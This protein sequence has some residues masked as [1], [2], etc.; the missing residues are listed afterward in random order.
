MDVGHTTTAID[1]I[2]NN[3]GVLLDVQ[4]QS[5]RT[6]HCTTVTSGVE[7]TDLTALQIPSGTDGHGFLVVATE[8]ATDLEG[9]TVSIR[10]AKVHSHSFD[11]VISQQF[12]DTI[13]FNTADNLTRVVNTNNGL[14]CHRCLVSTTKS[15]NDRTTYNFK[16]G[17]VQIRSGKIVFTTGKLVSIIIRD[18]MCDDFGLRIGLWVR[19]RIGFA[20]IHIIAIT[21]TKQLSDIDRLIIG[22]YFSRVVRIHL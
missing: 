15:P 1:I 14:L 4:D 6:G 7:V 20:G 3:F 11:T 17:S 16:I 19:H 13:F 18:D 12:F 22:C 10:I 21:T 8:E 9:F 2:H 5:N